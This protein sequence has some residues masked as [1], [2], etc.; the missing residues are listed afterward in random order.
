MFIGLSFLF[1]STFGIDYTL[2]LI[3]MGG[4]TALYLVLGGYKSMTVIDM[5][6]GIIMLIGVGVL[7]VSILDEGDGL[8]S[9]TDGIAAINPKLTDVV[10][11]PGWW[12]LFS[13]VFLTSVAPM[14]MPQLVQKFYA[15][16]D[17]RA[18][19][20]GMIGSTI[21]ALIITGIGYFSGATTRFFLTPETAPMAFADGKPIFDAPHAG[22]VDTDYPRRSF[23]GDP[24]ADPVGIDVHPRGAGADLQFRG[25]Q[26]PVRGIHQQAG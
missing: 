21:F 10:G 15:I 9:I 18:I 4:F 20:V 2:A 11:P 22:A 13:L 1:R 25:G 3:L 16:K 24:A 8:A 12:P 23:G 6:F 17:N 14:A 5:I 26:G 7:L 19:K